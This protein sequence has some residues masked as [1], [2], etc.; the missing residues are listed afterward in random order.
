M[1]T[2]F[3]NKQMIPVELS[4]ENK[5]REDRNKNQVRIFQNSKGRHG[6]LKKTVELKHKTDG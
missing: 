2:D 1:Y 6:D 3:L 5:E 4:F